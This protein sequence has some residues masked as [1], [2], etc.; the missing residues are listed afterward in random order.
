[1]GP[2]VARILRSSMLQQLM[3]LA[4]RQLGRSSKKLGK[5][6][7]GQKIEVLAIVHAL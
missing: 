7:V 6:I 5:L 1:M 4:L 3:G 2:Q